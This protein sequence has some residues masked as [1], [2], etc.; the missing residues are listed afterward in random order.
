MSRR[1]GRDAVTAWLDAVANGSATM[2]QRQ[3][4]WA[5]RN[6]GLATLVEQARARGVHIVRLT[7]DSGRDLLA[8]S[9]EP[10]STL[11]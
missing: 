10:F 5:E 8:A 7:D 3:V 2:S 9:T 4:A 1:E 11:C 6:G